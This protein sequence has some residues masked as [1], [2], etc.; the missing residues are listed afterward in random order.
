M[1]RNIIKKINID[2][3]LNY[4][5]KFSLCCGFIGSSYMMFTSQDK[6]PFKFQDGLIGFSIGSSSGFFSPILIPAY[7]TGKG[8]NKIYLFIKEK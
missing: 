3:L 1:L 5:F 7:I 6:F 8:I 2:K 4:H